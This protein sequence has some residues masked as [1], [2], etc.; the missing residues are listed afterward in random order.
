M[1]AA[2]I[3]LDS[4]SLYPLLEGPILKSA[5]VKPTKINSSYKSY[6]AQNL[7]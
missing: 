7:P 1:A 3:R 6:K 5:G 2:M 4:A